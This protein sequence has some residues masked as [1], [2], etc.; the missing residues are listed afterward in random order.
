MSAARQ[1]LI[2]TLTRIR[3]LGETSLFFLAPA[4]PS[5][6]HAAAGVVAG[7]QVPGGVSPPGGT[8][9][10][11]PGAA[12]AAGGPGAAGGTA[13]ARRG[14][15]PRE[16]IPA[17][18]RPPRGHAD[19]RED[20]ARAAGALPLADGDPR[21]ARWRE[22]QHR[23]DSCRLCRLCDTRRNAVFGSGTRDT[24]LFVVGEGPGQRE[25]ER[26]EAFVGPA[27]ELLTKILKA[28]GFERDQVFITN[29]V[30]CRPPGNRAPLPDEVAACAPYLQ[31]QLEVVEPVVILALG[32]SATQALL[33]TSIPISRL[34]GRV[35]LHRGIPLVATYH[36]AALLRNPAYKRPT[37]DD[38]QLLRRVYDERMAELRVV[39]PAA[40]GVKAAPA[41]AATASNS[42]AAGGAAAPG[43][44]TTAGSTA[45]TVAGT[46]AGGSASAP[47]RP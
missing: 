43:V 29:I 39:S 12:R 11:G 40:G 3:E 16:P 42:T 8:A 37:W 30:K 15:A 14:P 47:V 33:E 34:R 5:H 7:R 44:A 4:G 17:R 24:R 28:I 46:T 25:D 32:S 27:G 20:A 41:E 36:P 22:L 23:V 35:H 6:D 21:E 1:R 9:A 26:G 45:S 19:E 2:R 13:P 10:G 31:A 38:V 18:H